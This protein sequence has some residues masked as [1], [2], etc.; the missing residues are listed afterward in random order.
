[1]LCRNLGRSGSVFWGRN[2]TSCF[3]PA[4]IFVLLLA[5]SLICFFTAKP[6]AGAERTVTPQISL[7][8]RYNDNIHFTEKDKES[9]SYTVVSPAIQLRQQDERGDINIKGTINSFTYMERSELDSIDSEI[10]ANGAYALSPVFSANAS[11]L[12]KND[13]QSD[14]D[15]TSSGLVS[16][17]SK[18]EQNQGALGLNWALSEKTTMGTKASLGRTIYEDP[19]YSDFTS[20]AYSMDFSH[21][22]SRFVAETTG[23]LHLTRSRYDY[24]FSQSDYTTAA[25]GFEKKLNEKFNL[26]AWA[27]PSLIETV[28][29]SFLK[30]EEWG[31]TAHC[32]LDGQFEKS[33]MN[34]SFTYDLQPDSFNG[35]SVKR[36]ALKGSYLKRMSSDLRLGIE[37]SYFRNEA[38]EQEIIS[39][40]DTSEDTFNVSPR[41][42]YQIT[43]DLE[44]EF[45]YN[46]SRIDDNGYAESSRT[47]NSILVQLNWRHSFDKY[48]L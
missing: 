38:T 28:Y 18:R 40:T 31:T 45:C 32:S 26:I 13:Y 1:L 33:T 10:A 11:G 17:N 44:L 47:Q 6:V 15:I 9:D 48:D 8:S 12:Y 21:N 34:L 37:A 24:D 22:L 4:P 25:L 35:T 29:G 39:T 7:G 36:M 46:F 42:L 5:V 19:E 16:T 20:Q 2:G 41:G 23:L 3:Q 43:N 30:T 14:R 27:G